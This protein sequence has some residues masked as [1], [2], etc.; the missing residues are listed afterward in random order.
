MV[1]QR[2]FPLRAVVTISAGGDAILGELLAMD[3]LMTVFALC[4]SRC[5]VC[6]N[7]FGLHVRRLVTIDACRSLVGANQGKVRFRVI[8]AGQLFPGLGRVAG[9]AP[10]RGS[11]GAQWLHALRKLPFVRILMAGYAR[12]VLP[13]IEDDWLRTA[14]CVGL[15]LVAIAARDGYVSV[16]QDKPCLFMARQ[17]EG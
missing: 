2:R 17:R 13:V 12:Q 3:F 1:E 10:G 7:E 9:F 8:E 4:R 14:F 6:R 11:I 5:K 15:L 16:G